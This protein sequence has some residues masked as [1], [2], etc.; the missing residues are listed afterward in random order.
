LYWSKNLSKAFPQRTLNTISQKDVESHL[1]ILIKKNKYK[2]WQ[3]QQA[4][5][6]FR[7]L[8]A[9]CLSLPWTKPWPLRIPDLPEFHPS[10]THFSTPLGI[11]FGCADKLANSALTSTEKALSNSASPSRFKDTMN[12]NGVELH[13]PGL[14]DKI[15]TV[16]RTMHYAY[17][18]EK[19]YLEW[20]CRYLN[21]IDLKEPDT[22][23]AREVKTYLE[24]LGIPRGRS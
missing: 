20:I 23:G 21:F 18:T 5:D 24:Y 8:F 6:S 10:G 1:D 2:E 13:C 11:S 15:R 3:L 14:L 17:T 19:T 7:L 9:V 12:S 22:V 4:N 16:I